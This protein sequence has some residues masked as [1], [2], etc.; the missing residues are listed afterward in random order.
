MWY[1]CALSLLLSS[2]LNILGH[3]CWGILWA[4]ASGLAMAEL[5]VDGESRL[6]N[7]NPFRLDRFVENSSRRGKKIGATDVGE[8]W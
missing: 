4:P 1:S 7:M 5:I 8:Q 2:F 3:N 6:F